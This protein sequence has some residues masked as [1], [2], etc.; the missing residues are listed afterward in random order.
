MGSEGEVSLFQSYYGL[1]VL[2]M[3][4]LSNSSLVNRWQKENDTE[5]EKCSMKFVTRMLLEFVVGYEESW[6][7]QGGWRF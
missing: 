3:L 2:R 4:Y 5:V 6:K 1:L 7:G